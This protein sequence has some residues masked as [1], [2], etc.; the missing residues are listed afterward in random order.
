MLYVEQHLHIVNI[1]YDLRE[2]LE[3][4]IDL[5]LNNTCVCTHYL[6]NWVLESK[7]TDLVEDFG[8]KE[9]I[10]PTTDWRHGLDHILNPQTL[11]RGQKLT[12][13]LPDD[14]AWRGERSEA[15]AMLWYRCP[16]KHLLSASITRLP[17][18]LNR[19]IYGWPHLDYI[20]GAGVGLSLHR[21]EGMGQKL[22]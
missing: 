15:L 8:V 19:S 6:P 17:I 9:E 20:E 12:T 7:C 11:L 4:Q 14:L 10:N 16:T 1:L 3:K 18:V 5:S 13:C 22:Q 21:E 2:T